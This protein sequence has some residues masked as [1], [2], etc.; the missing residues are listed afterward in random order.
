MAPGTKTNQLQSEQHH[1]LKEMMNNL[2]WEQRLVVDDSH[3][4]N[5]AI[6]MPL[7]V[8]L[9]KPPIWSCVCAFFSQL[10]FL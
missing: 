5:R 7:D 6:D 3:F 8:L 10:H 9:G 4:D 2:P 1:E